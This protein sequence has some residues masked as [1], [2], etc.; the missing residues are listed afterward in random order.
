MKYQRR[1]GA[2]LSALVISACATG[3][4]TAGLEGDNQV[5]YR[6]A[7]IDGLD[8]SYREAG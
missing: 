6:T 1:V 8:I 7:A 2:A 5:Y 3:A 4:E